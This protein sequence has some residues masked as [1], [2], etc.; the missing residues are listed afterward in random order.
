MICK[1]WSKSSYGLFKMCPFAYHG[2]KELGR[3]QAFSEKAAHGKWVHDARMKVCLGQ[4]PLE[5]AIAEAPTLEAANAIEK[6]VT[7][8][9]LLEHQKSLE[10]E[11]QI[12]LGKTGKPV[13]TRNGATHIMIIDRFGPVDDV[14]EVDDVKFVH[15]LF[16]NEN[17]AEIEAYVYAAHT[18]YPRPKIVRFRYLFARSG[19]IVT[20]EFEKNEVK[21]LWKK[22]KEYRQEILDAEPEPNPG[23]HCA[24]WYGTGPCQFAGKECPV[25]LDSLPIVLEN[26][27]PDP[28][29]EIKRLPMSK[30]A[31]AAFMAVLHGTVQPDQIDPEIASLVWT[32]SEQIKDGRSAVEKIL[33]SA[34]AEKNLTFPYGKKTLGL[35]SGESIKLFGDS[36]AGREAALEIMIEAGW[37][38]RKIAQYIQMRPDPFRRPKPGDESV[39]H[40]IVKQCVESSGRVGIKEI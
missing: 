40:K 38:A 26:A 37:P 5:D 35:A 19:N 14:L 25:A 3:S 10:Y 15:P 32:A 36:L 11:Q 8:D 1:T 18:R 9:P 20:Y 21:G 2:Y 22:L 29:V 16:E 39:C 4:M 12:L 30:A 13:T 34:M 6:L 31:P 24:N 27:L 7:E 28:A 23:D 17:M 33:K